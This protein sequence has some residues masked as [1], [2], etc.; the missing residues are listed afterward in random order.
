[1]NGGTISGLREHSHHDA[2][3][4]RFVE[5]D[6]APHWLAEAPLEP[7]PMPREWI[8]P[9]LAMVAVIA[10]VGGML[11]WAGATLGRLQPVELSSFVAAL[12]VPPLLIGIVWLLLRQGSRSEAR[13]FTATAQA[14]RSEALALEQVVA[15]VRRSIAE[16]RGELAEHT[17]QLMM[18]GE[19]ATDRLRGVR[20]GIA[21]QVAAIDM[22]TEALTLAATH[23][24]H[25]LGTL[26]DT[27]P[28][29]HAETESISQRLEATGLAASERIAALDAALAAVAQRGRDADEV[30][31]GAAQR[32]A[33]HIARMEA[34]S[35]SAGTRLESVIG[36]MSGAIDEVLD[37]AANAIDESRKAITAQGDA[38]IAMI[39]AN[40]AAIERAGRE[41][42]DQ[43]AERMGQIDGAIRTLAGHIDERRR[44]SEA[45]LATLQTGLGAFDERFAAVETQGIARAQ[46]VSDAIGERLAERRRDGEAMFETLG[47]GLE[48]FDAQFAAVQSHGIA[49]AQAVSDAIGERL[50]ERRRDGEAMFETLGQGLETFDAQFAAVQ[51]HGIARAQ[52]AS[53]AIG[54][55]LAERQRDGDAMFAALGQGLESFDAQFAAVQSHGIARAQAASD[56]IAERLAERQRDGEAMF[57]TLG[58]GLESFDAQFA[59]IEAQ[60]IARVQAL[61]NAIDERLAERRRDS[62]SMLATLGE[63]LDAFD[64]RFETM[65]HDGIERIQSIAGTIEARLAE[66]RRDGEALLAMLDDGLTGFDEKFDALR[67]SGV[68]RVQAVAG[69]IEVL[70]QVADALT[71]ALDGN[72]ETARRVVRTAE[73]VLTALDAAAREMDETLPGAL[74]R[75]DTRVTASR[76]I[77][78]RAKPELLALV[79]AAESTHEAIEAIAGVVDMQRETLTSVQQKLLDTLDLG[80]DRISEVREIAD[81]TI[82][83]T[84][85]FAEDAAPRLSEAMLRIRDTAES[86]SAKARQTLAKVLP[87]VARDLEAQ[88]TRA[89]ANA[90]DRAVTNQVAELSSI[91]NQ[92]V[93]SAIEAGERLSRQMVKITETG[94]ELETRMAAARAEREVADSEQFSRRVTTLIEA[95]NSA[96]IDIAK[97]LSTDVSDTAWAAYL[98]GDRGVFTRRAVRLVEGAEARDIALLYD[99]DEGFSDQV[100]RYI[101]DFEAM[102]RQVLSLRDGSSMGVTLLS[103]D[104]GKLYVVLAQAIERLRN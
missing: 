23:A 67:V 94:E 8:A 49:R 100:N 85:R 34:T 82:A 75:L 12:C 91:A 70:S 79:T 77:V 57:A 78:A 61:S 99:G 43:L 66:R 18:L 83:T 89:L 80:K 72:D 73:E 102:L 40:G 63:G 41:G 101:H 27:L 36:T 28:R 62:E 55:R 104:M 97:S 26:L 86:A 48:A 52:A 84:V 103:S 14:M 16:S 39:E 92:A 42:A 69:S 24:E 32:L 21:E 9:T 7:E 20:A 25:R 5:Q 98:K 87:D 71:E 13:R 51:S 6:E 95:M 50:A 93:A 56:A 76:D 37:R 35:E 29:A 2:D 33:A 88:G 31:G 74:D 10:W 58:Q 3:D 1:M 68:E 65:R 22:T 96:S 19:G 30:A 15:T 60:G 64:G 47:Q 90:V 45:L 54:E 44:D 53:D 81:E 46:A 4:D 17:G 38:T 11:V 59:A